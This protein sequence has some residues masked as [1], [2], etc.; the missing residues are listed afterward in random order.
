VWKGEITLTT[1]DKY[2]S[3]ID[4]FKRTGDTKAR[5]KA[6]KKPTESKNWKQE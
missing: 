5:E 4:Y 2:N 3:V 1:K 6:E